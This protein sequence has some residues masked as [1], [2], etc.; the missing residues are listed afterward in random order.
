MLD[1]RVDVIDECIYNLE[2]QGY[3][4]LSRGSQIYDI[5]DQPDIWME[6]EIIS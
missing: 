1:L 2:V 3:L 4:K 5:E 6:A